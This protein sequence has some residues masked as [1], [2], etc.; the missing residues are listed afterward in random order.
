MEAIKT[1]A[2]PVPPPLPVASI[3]A[4]A[5]DTS[6]KVVK[7][8]KRAKVT[9]DPVAKQPSDVLSESE[10]T[11]GFVNTQTD[12]KPGAREPFIQTRSTPTRSKNNWLVISAIVLLVASGAYY[13]TR[14]SKQ[15]VACNASLTEAS[16]QFTAGNIQGARNTTLQVLASC[17]G[18]IKERATALLA[19]IDKASV[20]KTGCD[21]LVRMGES[22]LSNRQLTSAR[23]SLDQLDV[24]CAES[25]AVKTLTKRIAESQT[26]SLAIEADLRSQIA[27]GNVKS[28]RAA[29][30]QLIAQNRENSELPKFRE[31]IQALAKKSEV[32]SP[33]PVPAP[34][35]QEISAAG[36][37][38]PGQTDLAQAFLRDAEQALN[39]LK[40][41]A[42]RTYVESAR[43]MDPNNAQAANLMRRIK[44]KELQYL[45]DETTIK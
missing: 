14:P 32:V 15:E 36:R 22:Q 1:I 33:S 23:S 12:N 13:L 9:L 29:F 21:K 5:V 40:F 8:N 34:P 31:E 44:D 6:V 19:Q 24:S 37:S 17:P 7:D 42:A 45:R 27:Q 30:D 41:D 39:Q 28:A 11:E 26:I 18:E 2:K 43:R 20:A 38:N 4:K 10:S 16:G 3:P 35:P 25:A